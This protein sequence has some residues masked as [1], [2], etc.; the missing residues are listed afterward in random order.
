[1][2]RSSRRVETGRYVFVVV[3]SS[4]MGSNWIRLKCGLG[5]MAVDETKGTKQTEG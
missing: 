3:L 5:L 1:M 4:E 2:V